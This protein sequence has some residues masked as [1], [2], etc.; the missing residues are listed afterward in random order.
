MLMLSVGVMA[1]PSWA[2]AKSGGDFDQNR[3]SWKRL[4]FEGK[5][6]M[7][8]ASTRVLLESLTVA[9][10]APALIESPHGAVAIP[11]NADVLLMT[12]DIEARLLFERKKWEGRVWFLPTDG[13]ALQRIRHKPG[14]GAGDKRYRIWH[15]YLAG[16]SYAFEQDWI[17][18]YQIVGR[19]AGQ[20]SAALPWSRRHMYPAAQTAGTSS[21]AHYALTDDGLPSST[22]LQEGGGEAMGSTP[23]AINYFN[24]T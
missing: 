5:K 2:R 17:S 12:A 23:P 6:A 20:R 22:L 8:S 11:S 24:A 21:G 15:V 18:L 19:K 16:C 3:V 9:E 1:M 7:G 13:T 10:A 14:K 4:V